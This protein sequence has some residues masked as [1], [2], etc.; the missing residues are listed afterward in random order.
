MFWRVRGK[1]AGISR[2]P[3]WWGQGEAQQWPQSAKYLQSAQKQRWV[4]VNVET[5]PTCH[6]NSQ[7]TEKEASVYKRERK[8]KVPKHPSWRLTALHNGLSC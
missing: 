8:E 1:S 3:A 6:L 7:S 5:G 2:A 4:E